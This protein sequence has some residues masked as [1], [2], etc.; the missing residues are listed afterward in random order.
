MPTIGKSIELFNSIAFFVSTKSSSV[1]SSKVSCSNTFFIFL[2][3]VIIVLTPHC[4]LFAYSS[5]FSAYPVFV[6]LFL[7]QMF[8]SA[9]SPSMTH[10]GLQLQEV[11]DFEALN[12]LPV[13]NEV[14]AGLPPLNLIRSTKLHLTTEPPISCRC[15]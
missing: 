3:S 13:R 15:C 11:G 12:C 5:R 10:N 9:V 14:K 7:A 2:S 8:G 4:F 6:C 1:G